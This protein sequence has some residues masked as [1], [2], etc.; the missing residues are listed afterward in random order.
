MKIE[1][2]LEESQIARLLGAI[3]LGIEYE[4]MMASIGMTIANADTM[5]MRWISGV[6]DVRDEIMEKA[7]V[8]EKH[9][10]LCYG[11]DK[12]LRRMFRR[13]VKKTINKIKQEMQERPEEEVKVYKWNANCNAY[14]GKQISEILGINMNTVWTRFQS[15]YANKRWGVKWYELPGG[16]LKRMVDFDDLKKWAIADKNLHLGRPAQKEED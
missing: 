3:E 9:V 4:D 10:D 2:D 7:G 16:V 15:K 1:L 11:T 5:S 14:S 12:Q 13:F 6:A 8:G